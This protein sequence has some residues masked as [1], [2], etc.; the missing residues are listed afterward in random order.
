M[1]A[2]EVILGSCT[3]QQAASGERPLDAAGREGL[4]ATARQMASE[5][6][7]VIA[8]ARRS[9]AAVASAERELTFLGL[10]RMIDPPRPENQAVERCRQAGITPVMITGDHPLTAKAVARELGILTDG[11]PV[12][13]AE[14]EAMD[15]AELERDVETIQVDLQGVLRE[16][17]DSNPR[18]PARQVGPKR[19]GGFSPS[20]AQTARSSDFFGRFGSPPSFAWFHRRRARQAVG[21]ETSW[22]RH[23]PLEPGE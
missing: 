9:D 17:R 16:R 4:L 18:P 14:L 2:P 1:G 13:G 19:F 6:L 12:T 10:M 11:R 7:R 20:S 15:N 22:K 21:M 5:A 3:R 23:R 8:V